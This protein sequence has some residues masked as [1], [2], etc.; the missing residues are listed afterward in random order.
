EEEEKVDAEEEFEEEGED[1][2]EEEGAEDSDGAGEDSDDSEAGEADDSDESDQG[3]EDEDGDDEDESASDENLDPDTS[4]IDE[5]RE[6]NRK[7]MEL[8]QQGQPPKDEKE[9]E[10]KTR[11][12]DVNELFGELSFDEI[13]GDKDLFVGFLQNV[14]SMA[15]ENSVERVAT[16]MPQF[17]MN[18]MQQQKVLTDATDSF[19][20]ANKEL[21]PH[22]KVVA[23]LT[24]EVVQEHQDWSLEKVLVETAD[25]S[26]K[27]LN[28]KK[29]AIKKSSEEQ[30]PGK[31]NTP[32][33]N[34]KVRSGKRKAPKLSKLQSEIND[35]L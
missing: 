24:N 20:S 30:S 25:R 3:E 1:S 14:M 6:Q 22:K 34:K 21:V 35:L 33:L 8:L 23:M 12:K 18:Q 9:E 5:L 10:K 28:L 19:Y 11:P 32:A 2:D 29:E 13:M 4:V 26:Y 7:L 17:V 15:T 31:K 16:T 27:L